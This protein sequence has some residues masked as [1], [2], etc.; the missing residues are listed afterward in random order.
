MAGDGGA[1]ANDLKPFGTDS[2]FVSECTSCHEPVHG[3]D[4]VYALPITA[5]KSA[6]REVE[7]NRA[8]AL[9][10]SLPYRHYVERGTMF[11]DPKARTMATLS[12][13]G[14]AVQV[15]RAGETKKGLVP[16]YPAGSVLA[17]V[18]WSQR[19]DPHWF[20]ARIPDN[21]KSIEFVEVDVSGNGR[22]YRCY[23]GPILKERVFLQ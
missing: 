2:R 4:F 5:A 15:A 12:G 1:G 20:G 14:A 23:D 9:P 13:N 11:V 8:A 3:N 16:G 17:L 19:E 6:R 10:Q 22:T 21:P 18:T 7:N